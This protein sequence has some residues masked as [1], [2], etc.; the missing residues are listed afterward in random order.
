MTVARSPSTLGLTQKA[1][2]IPPNRNGSY[3]SV[4][5]LGC[6][7]A[8]SMMPAELHLISAAEACWYHHDPTTALNCRLATG[9][10]LPVE[11]GRRVPPA[12]LAVLRG[13][14]APGASP[15]SSDSRRPRQ[16]GLGH[17][18]NGQADLPCSH[19]SRSSHSGQAKP[20]RIL[21]AGSDEQIL[22]AP[23]SSA[24]RLPSSRLTPCGAGLSLDAES[25]AES[26]RQLIAY[27]SQPCDANPPG[28]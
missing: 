22:L 18:Q 23:S 16:P 20:G 5:L 6:R 28:S 4:I 3:T 17:V 27:L 26:R 9:N 25:Y 10:L 12:E 21:V 1:S 8:R 13:N 24:G 2:G 19:D 7:T 11:F 14:D 15:G